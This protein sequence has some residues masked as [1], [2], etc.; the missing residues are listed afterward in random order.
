[1][2]RS[3][4]A[5]LTVASAL[6]LAQPAAAQVTA[7]DYDA[8]WLW[9]GV[10]PPKVLASARTLYVLQG[11][12]RADHRHGTVD[13]EAQ[14]IA[15]PHL[16]DGEVWLVYR[17]N[18]L[19]WPA[20]LPGFLTAQV[21]R[22]RQA[23]NKVIGVQIDFDAATRH[24]DT[25][26]TALR[27]LR[28]HLPPDCRLGI[29]G[30]LDW[31]GRIDPATLDRLK[32]VVDELVIQTYQGRR[33]IPGYDAYMPNLNRLALPFKVGLVE[34]GDW[35]EPPGLAG[36]PWFRGYVVFLQGGTAAP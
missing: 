1:M 32:G 9:G 20:R 5:P 22:W 4:L 25:Y 34:G 8:F 30:L 15:I 23:G 26:A 13:I 3:W 18:T 35:Q 27:D 33:T 29:T 12:I 10:T 31:S 2:H 28:R 24:L 36:N 21:A 11:E 14:G 6:V 17:A 16:K 7:T 19:D